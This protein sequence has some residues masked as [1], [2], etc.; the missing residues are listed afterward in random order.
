MGGNVGACISGRAC[1]ILFF[2]KHQ[3]GSDGGEGDLGEVSCHRKGISKY[4][5]SADK[6]VEDRRGSIGS[7][8]QGKGGENG[9]GFFFVIVVVL[10]IVYFFDSGFAALPLPLFMNSTRVHSVRDFFCRIADSCGLFG[11]HRFRQVKLKA[12]KM[13]EKRHGVQ[14]QGR[15]SFFWFVMMGG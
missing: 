8:Y 11:G 15:W 10:S 3:V 13:N 6:G 7:G 1:S 12:E 2:F 9:R 14:G 5:G 4:K